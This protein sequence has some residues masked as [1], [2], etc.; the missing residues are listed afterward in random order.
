MEPDTIQKM[1][2]IM[3]MYEIVHGSDFVN[4]NYVAW[5]CLCPN[6]PW[7][8]SD[9]ACD[10]IK[11]YA[12]HNQ[13]VL[14]VSA[15]MSGITAPVFLLSTV[16]LAIAE[17]LAGLV[18]AQLIRPGLPV[19]CSASLTYGYM[20]SASW[21][22]A[23]PDTALMLAAHVQMQREFYKLPTRAQTGVT[24]SKTTDFQAGMETMQSL[25][26]TA[27]AGVNVTSQT[28]GSLA[29][30]LTSSLEKTV[31]DDEIIGRVRWLLKG[32]EIDEEQ[33]GME[34][35][36]AAEPK[37]AFLENDSTFDHFRDFFAPTISDWSNPD[38]WEEAGSRDVS[39]LAHNRVQKILSEAP[40]TLISEELDKDLKDFITSVEEGA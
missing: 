2:E 35:L 25:L 6:S 39:E 31:L 7:F 22:C 24:S 29:N 10:C 14:I 12:E 13:P 38:E 1:E 30:L 23:S 21:E 32:M 3:K 18:L 26:F 34:D 36:L 19:I 4:N 17:D 40:E 27:L 16:V 8:Y 33:F 5:Q 11:V 15:P 20:R 9:Y 28:V 37:S